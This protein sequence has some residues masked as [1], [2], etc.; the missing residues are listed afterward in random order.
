[1]KLCVSHN[2]V[3]LSIRSHGFSHGTV[4]RVTCIAYHIACDNSLPSPIKCYTDMCLDFLED[5]V[6]VKKN[7][8][9]SQNQVILSIRSHRFSHGTVFRVTCIAY[10]IACDNSLPS[11]IKC[12]TDMCRQFVGVGL[13]GNEAVC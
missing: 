7:V 12:Y 4:L 11:P 10:H 5:F 9:Y 3:I 6:C 1:M 2:Q 13:C 8:C